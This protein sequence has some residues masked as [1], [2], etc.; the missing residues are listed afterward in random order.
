MG[1]FAKKMKKKYNETN[2]KSIIVYL[3][4]R[5]L[6][7][8]CMIFQI[9][10]GNF[11]N[12]FMCILSLFLFTIPSI[13][14]EKL[15]IGLPSVLETIIYLFIFSATI[16]GEIN[17]FY[18]VIPFWD[19]ILHTL[20]GFLCAGIGFSL[21]DLLNQNSKK[22]SLSPLYVVIVAF[23]FSM[24]IGILWEFYEFTA[25][26]VF[27]TDMQKD[28]V[29]QNISSVELNRNGENIPI[30]VNN[31]KKTEIYLKDGIIVTIDN[32]YL[33]I[34]IIDTMKDLFVNFIGAIIFS[35]IGFLYIQNREKYKFTENFIPTKVY[36]I[37]LEKSIYLKEQINL[38]KNDRKLN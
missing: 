13:I 20:N 23:C 36:D 29:V 8:I 31:I 21:V 5:V 34:G 14:S 18:G 6:V 12:V 32:G 11:E 15:K 35:I 28:R 38:K 9:L 27:R 1:K 26:S 4:L 16:L 37:D 33:D 24:T 7:I 25:D 17:N 22:I 30:K 10:M 3:I 2:K 19:T